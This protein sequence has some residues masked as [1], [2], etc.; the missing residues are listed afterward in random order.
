MS[1]KIGENIRRLR[2]ENGMTQEELA[3]LLHVS[4][5][6][7]SKW[8]LNSA[9]PDIAMVIPLARVFHVSIDTL[10]GYSAARAEEEI[11]ELLTQHRQLKMEGMHPEA[12]VLMEGARKKFP[13]DFRIM[14][15]YLWDVAGGTVSPSK[16]M[17]NA[18]R[19][20]LAKLCDCILSRCMEEPLRLS[21]LNMKAKLFHAEGNTAQALE[22]LSALPSWRECAG[23]KLEGLYEKDSAEYR[24]WNHRN[25]YQLADGTANKLIR[26]VWY[27]DDAPIEERISR[28]EALCE[29]FSQMRKMSD[30]PIFKIME[31]MLYSDLS[32]LL[33]FSGGHAE[34]GIRIQEHVLAAAKELTDAAKTDDVLRELLMSTYLTDNLLHWTL[35]RLKSSPQE[36]LAR[37]REHAEYRAMLE[38]YEEAASS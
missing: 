9:C 15:R 12:K 24:Y 3:E 25:L 14:E 23:N 38:R 21:A 10:M 18:N 2:R 29:L 11:Q 5:A 30:E 4:C 17:L 27:Q 8:E 1:Q 19:E 33:I 22:I 31:H 7:V 26:S 34:D 35:H 6:A 20:D 28:C 32:N 13:E 36:P 37:L 16:E